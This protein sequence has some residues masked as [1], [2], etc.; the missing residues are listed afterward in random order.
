MPGKQPKPSRRRRRP[1]HRRIAAPR[2]GPVLPGPGMKNTF[3]SMGPS[4]LSTMYMASPATGAVTNNTELGMKLTHFF[5]YATSSSAG[6]APQD[7]TNYWWEAY[8][9]LFN[10]YSG[11]LPQQ[12]TTFCRVRRL[13]VWVLPQSGVSTTG[14]AS[15]PA[16]NANRV[17]SVNCQVPGSLSGSPATA[18]ATNTQ[19]TN[20]L[21]QVDTKWKKVLTCDLQKTFQSATVRP[22]FGFGTVNTTAQCLFQMQIVD[23]D[24][25]TPYLSQDSPFKIQVK[26][27]LDLDQPIL[28]V[29]VAKLTV[30][31]NDD[32]RQPGVA[33]DGDPFE[34]TTEQYVQIKITGARDYMR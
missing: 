19:V 16:Q 23:P 20:V 25:G 34:E 13:H 9:N 31:R 21:P 32:F 30:F 14:T 4:D 15:F 6:S 11:D 33:F 5:D 10:D 29:Q 26:V 7:V 1:A 3:G 27:Q 12:G 28:P 8:Q 24:T 18:V 22:F 2:C 17:F